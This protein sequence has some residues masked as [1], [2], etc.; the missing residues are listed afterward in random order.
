VK[1]SPASTTQSRV[2]SVG[3]FCASPRHANGSRI[4]STSTRRPTVATPGEISARTARATIQ[5][6]DQ[7][8]SV[9]TSTTQVVKRIRA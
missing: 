2:E 7:S 8:N 4:A 9:A 5:L 6:P 3:S 1:P